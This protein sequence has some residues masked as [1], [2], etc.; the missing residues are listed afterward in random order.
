[1]RAS[2]GGAA[3]GPGFRVGGGARV[4]TVASIGGRTI[5]AA[6]HWTAASNP[7]GAFVHGARGVGVAGVAGHRTVFR[8]ST[9]VRRQGSIIRT[10]FRGTGYFN[11][12]WYRAHPAAWRAAAWNTAAYWNWARYATIA[13]FCSYPVTPVVYGYGSDLVYENNQVYY[14]GTPVAT[15]QEYS[16]QAVDLAAAGQAAKPTDKE[17]WQSFGVF[18]IVHGEDEESNEVFQIAI[19]KDGVIRGNYHN[20]LTDTTTPIYGSADKKSQRAAWIIGD[21]KDTVFETGVGNLTLPDTEILVHIGKNSTQQ[22]TLVRL[23]QPREEK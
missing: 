20:E 4:N 22:W 21:N 14:N 7:Y 15:A 5:G 3:I 19:N 13:A 8:N 17:E 1:V 18:A 12:G 11:A 9:A 6:S 10:E 23:D 16:T 2:R